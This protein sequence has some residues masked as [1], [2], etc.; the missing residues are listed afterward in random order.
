MIFSQYFYL[1]YEFL[2]HILYWLVYFIQIF[3]CIFFDCFEHSFNHYF[4]VSYDCMQFIL[5]KH[6]CPT[7]VGNELCYLC[8]HISCITLLRLSIVKVFIW[9]AIIFQLKYLHCSSGVR[10]RRVKA[11]SLEGKTSVHL[12]RCPVWHLHF[13][14]CK[15]FTSERTM[16][17]G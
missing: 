5:I 16:F 10:F 15:I 8:F 6:H 17:T 9:S 3:K 11:H 7:G 12:L 1:F 14:Q 2:I 4:I 13:S